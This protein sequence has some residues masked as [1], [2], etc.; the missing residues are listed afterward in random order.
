MVRWWRGS[1][2]CHEY[3][4]VSREKTF[5]VFAALL[6]VVHAWVGQFL[7]KCD[8]FK[9]FL[10]GLHLWSNGNQMTVKLDVTARTGPLAVP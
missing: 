3:E 9:R 10:S 6:G 5:Y 4:V 8:T 7:L 2:A 1:S